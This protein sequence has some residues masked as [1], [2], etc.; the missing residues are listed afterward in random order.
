MAIP[1]GDLN[2]TR[3]R[4]WVTLLLIAVNIGVFVLW[5]PWCERSLKTDIDDH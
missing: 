5:Q 2:P 4:G 1:L 3:R